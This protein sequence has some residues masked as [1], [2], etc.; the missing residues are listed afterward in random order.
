MGSSYK[1][2]HAEN[3]FNT[4]RSEPVDGMNGRNFNQSRSSRFWMFMVAHTITT[5]RY[6]CVEVGDKDWMLPSSN[7]GISMRI[8]VLVS[9]L[10]RSCAQG[11]V[12]KP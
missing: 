12:D 11:E 5:S 1:R 2:F 4:S 3:W 10:A 6:E 7:P 9:H 8:S